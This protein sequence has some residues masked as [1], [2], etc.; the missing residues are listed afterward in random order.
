MD[1]VSESIT[2]TQ[3][4]NYEDAFLTPEL[5]K[6]IYGVGGLIVAYCTKRWAPAQISSVRSRIWPKPPTQ[7]QVVDL[8]SP[9]PVTEHTHE[10]ATQTS[11]T[12]E[13]KPS[14]AMAVTRSQTMNSDYC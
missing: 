9:S 12:I 5:W 11:E 3:S 10:M 7:P 14:F 2:E 6:L 4:M 13:T 1:S 8:Q